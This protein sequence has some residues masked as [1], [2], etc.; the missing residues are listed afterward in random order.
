MNV[1]SGKSRFAVLDPLRF[2]AALFVLIYH[3]SIFYDLN[4]HT[5]Y[6]LTVAKYGYLGVPFFFMLSGFVISS[7]A[8]KATP[9]TF[10]VARARRLYPAFVACLIITLSVAYFC[11]G[12]VWPLKDTI[13]NALILNDYFHIAN[14]DGVYWTLQAE[15]KFYG[16][17]FILISMGQFKLH[18][19]W[20]PIWLAASCVHFYTKQPFFMG[21]FINPSYSF[22]FIAGATA[23]LMHK[24]KRS[25]MLNIY[26][27]ISAVFGVTVAG[28]QVNQFIS[29]VIWLDVWVARAVVLGFYVFFYALAHG[30]LSISEP[31]WWFVYLGAMSYPLYLL[32][33]RTGKTLIEYYQSSIPLSV[34]VPLVAVFITISALLVHLLIEKPIS[35]MK[36]L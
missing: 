23:L 15:L 1:V 5:Q 17:V 8:D 14:I 36:W 11:T 21:W 34:L 35:R 30:R 10:A 13:L 2:V 33:N 24:H 18:Q 4:S 16:C 12:Q 28:E 19:Y 25:L 3:Y 20:L 26:F 22:Y 7:S 32:H 31:P 29:H 27:L 6:F 9:L